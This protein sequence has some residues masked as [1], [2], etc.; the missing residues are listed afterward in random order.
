MYR[1]IGQVSRRIRAA[2]NKY[3]GGP[4]W[5]ARR[6]RHLYWAEKFSPD[7]IFLLGLLD[8]A[9]TAAELEDYVSKERLLRVQQ[10]LNPGTHTRLTEDKLAFHERCCRRGFPNTVV[11]AV[12]G[13]AETNVDH[14]WRI[15]DRSEW[16][17]FLE[18]LSGE[19]ILKPVKGVH[20][21]G[22]MRIRVTASGI[23][24]HHGQARNS[25]DLMRSM[26]VTGYRAWLVQENLRAHP[27]LAKVS[28]TSALQTVRAATYV[29][30]HGQ[31]SLLAAWLRVIGGSSV[32]DNFNFGRAGNLVG[33]IALDSG[34]VEIA[35]G[36]SRDGLGLVKVIEHP[37]TGATLQG[38]PIPYWEQLR[39]VVLDAAK[40]FLPLRTIG[41]DIG[42][43]ANG[44]V[45]VEGN[46]TWDP[47][48][49]NPRLGAIYRAL[50]K[51]AAVRGT[52]AP[53]SAAM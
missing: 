31:A 15:G 24:D 29:D 42:I 27:D 18:N 40:A 9:I 34:R 39:T 7:E 53:L 38:F 28:G 36:S 14:I 49:G 6:F 22:I 33:R 45:L 12:C 44:P 47:L 17:R 26:E 25:D 1:K 51:D 20:G 19:F 48:P 13:M 2:E 5:T 8:P 46:V 43:T 3:R 10:L 52:T 37:V 41:W 21:V 11:L 30:R 35:F 32:F 4:I 50:K 16:S 23:F